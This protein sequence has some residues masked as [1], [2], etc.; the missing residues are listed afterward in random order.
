[1][2][3]ITKVTMKTKIDNS[4]LRKQIK[5]LMIDKDLEWSRGFL[6]SEIGC[7]QRSMSMA[8]S[9]LRTGP[10]S[11]RILKNLKGYLKSL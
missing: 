11:M 2:K 6:A 4:R 10:A 1:M 9:G 8:L 7:N 5:H 3:Q